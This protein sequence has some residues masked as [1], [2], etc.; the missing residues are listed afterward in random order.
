M[1]WEIWRYATGRCNLHAL[2]LYTD[3]E[4]DMTKEELLYSWSGKCSLNNEN[5]YCNMLMHMPYLF[6][7][8]FFSINKLIK[9]QDMFLFVSCEVDLHFLLITSRQQAVHAF[10]IIVLWLMTNV[11][12]NEICI[13]KSHLMEGVF[14][15]TF[16]QY[17]FFCCKNVIF[18]LLWLKPGINLVKKKLKLN[19]NSTTMCTSI[20]SIFSALLFGIGSKLFEL[21]MWNI[22]SRWG[23]FLT[24][25]K[26]DMI[27]ELANFKIR[28]TYQSH[29]I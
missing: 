14:P 3:F 20:I 6:D 25:G 4:G 11:G 19:V 16:Y 12:E 2:L 21:N 27:T 28:S 13:L 15:Y 29:E 22:W 24:K 5:N 18:D 7:Y 10:L 26:L 23:V 17:F 1:P 8:S 9:P